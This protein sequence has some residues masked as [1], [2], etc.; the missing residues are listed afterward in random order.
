LFG[1]TIDRGQIECW[2]CVPSQSSIGALCNI[3]EA[4]SVSA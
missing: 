3:L 4:S 1:Q 2:G